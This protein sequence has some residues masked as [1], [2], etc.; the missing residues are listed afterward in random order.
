M[1]KTF[2]IMFV[3]TG[4]TC[5]SPMAEGALKILLKKE[6]KG[7]FEVCSSGT[8][9]ASRFPATMYAIEAAKIWD[10]DISM[11]K[12][13]P[14]TKQLIEQSDLIFALTSSHYKE[15]VK[16]KKSAKEYTYLLK[17]FPEKGGDGE[18]VVD[19][20]GQDL[21]KYNETFLE[22]GEILGKILPEIVKRIDEKN[23]A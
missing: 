15:I 3:C 20:I 11:H 1:S 13:Q 8:S 2:K 16:L 5:R 14:L 12:S 22:I 23:N 10:A 7:K 9:A 6:N 19:P 17:K 18:G 21:G 4:N